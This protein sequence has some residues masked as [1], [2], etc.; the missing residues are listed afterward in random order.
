[1]RGDVTCERLKPD[2]DSIANKALNVNNPSK[3]FYPYVKLYH[4]KEEDQPE[5]T[6]F[7]T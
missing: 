6:F 1:M 5:S 2:E 3:L 4:A 7:D